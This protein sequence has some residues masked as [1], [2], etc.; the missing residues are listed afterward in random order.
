MRRADRLFQIVQ[1]L[2]VRRVTTAAQL[3]ETLEISERT[4]Y[5]D[6]RDLMMS[7]IPIEGEAGV[8]YALP[9]SFDLPPLMF[10]KREIEALVLGAR[11]VKSWSDVEL[12]EA[13]GSA[14]VKIEAVL[15]ERLRSRLDE[16]T[17]FA[18]NYRGEPRAFA[19]NLPTLR[20]AILERRKIHF[21]YTRRDEAASQRT[22][23]PV[24]LFFWGYN[25]T[26]TAWCELRDDFR[27]FRVD[28]IDRLALQDETFE[29]E[30]GKT[31]EDFLE[32]VQSNDA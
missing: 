12:A 13:A 18:P 2:R 9:K 24:G 11:L 6:M 26:L 27:S 30:A 28:R 7:G 16:I 10:D 21:A 5:R 17:L 14:L 4:V 31:L 23:R 29:P 32:R 8:G 19:A 20:S 1:I 25:W 15:P 3:A 22:V